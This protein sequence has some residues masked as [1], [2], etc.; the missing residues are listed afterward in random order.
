LYDWAEQHKI[1]YRQAMRV[2]AQILRA[3]EALH[4]MGGV[5]RDVKGS[6]VLVTQEGRAVLTDFGLGTYRGAS[7]LT[8]QAEPVGTPQYLSPQALL[9]RERYW[10][11]GQPRYEASPADDV[12][13]AGVTA[14]YLVTGTYL[15]FPTDSEEG[16]GGALGVYGGRVSPEDLEGV[17][18]ECAA[19]I[20]QMLSDDPAARGHA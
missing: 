6:N 16:E 3:L 1:S 4:A 15:P 2:L 8:R 5:H 10:R 12:Y 17:P 13:A 11:R 20:L 18:P 7:V 14:W 19:P 9:H